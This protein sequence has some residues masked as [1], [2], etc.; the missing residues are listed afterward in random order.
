MNERRSINTRIWTDE[1]FEDLKPLEK[2]VWIYLLSNLNT[3]LIGI[4]EISVKRIAFDTGLDK[5]EAQHISDKFHQ[6]KKAFFY[7]GHVIIPNWIKNQ[8][9]NANMLKHARKL[10]NNLTPA[11]HD[12]LKRIGFE[13]FESLSNGFPMNNKKVREPEIQF[14]TSDELIFDKE[15]QAALCDYF[16]ITELGNERQWMDSIKFIMGLEKAGKLKLFK[17]QFEAYKTYRKESKATWNHKF[18]NFIC[19]GWNEQN[20]IKNL[21]NLKNNEDSSRNN[22]TSTKQPSRQGQAIEGVITRL[23]EEDRKCS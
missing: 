7:H 12:F 5:N 6:E 23:E 3:N 15:T 8:S 19:D 4:Y 21:E 14:P 13:S 1:W 17:E 18:P 22:S 11:I 2:L 16:G 20:W 9:M 10:Y